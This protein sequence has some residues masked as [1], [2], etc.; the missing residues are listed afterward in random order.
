MLVLCDLGASIKIPTGTAPALP[1]VQGL[2][3]GL[4]GHSTANRA[5]LG[6]SALTPAVLGERWSSA[7]VCDNSQKLSHEE[8]E[9]FLCIPGLF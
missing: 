4:G 8:L 9:I 5:L 2:P 1:G 7:D 6:L 3:A